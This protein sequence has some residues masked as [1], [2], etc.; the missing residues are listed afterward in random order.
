MKGVFAV[1]PQ[2]AETGQMAL[3]AKSLMLG[4]G[5]QGDAIAAA[6]MLN[7]P[8]RVSNLVKAPVP[9][10]W[11]GDPDVDGLQDARNITTAF[12]PFLRTSSLF[13]SAFSLG[14][15]RVPLMTQASIITATATAFVA[16]E[17]AAI[18]MSRMEVGQGGIDRQVANA[19]V[20]VTKPLLR[21]AGSAGEQM[22]SRELRRSI[23]PAVDSKFI[24]TIIDGL[25]PLVSAGSDAEAAVVDVK[26]LIEAVAPTVESRLIF[27]MAKDVAIAGSMM[28]LDGGWLFPDLTPTGG[29][30]KGIDVVV[31]EALDPGTLMLIDATGIAG[32]SELITLAA[33]DETSIQMETTPTGS[34]AA[35]TAT[36]MVSMYQTNS[37]AL[38]ATAFF[39]AERYT[40]NAAATMTVG[41][42]GEEGEAEGEG[43]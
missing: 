6:E 38:L 42:S 15:A 4:G 17:G 30:I 40:D 28:I 7:A 22:I 32:D 14:M 2:N 33:S 36:E 12:L 39:G 37:S 35:P 13:Y 10:H 9:A 8:P 20:I 3:L 31:S 27:G 19:L 29:Q 24:A 18:P 1:S 25:T 16:A 5:R 21:M 43:E 41:W 23:A 34:S 11:S 26:A